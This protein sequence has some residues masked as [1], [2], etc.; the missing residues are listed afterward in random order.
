MNMEVIRLKIKPISSFKT[1]WASDTLMGAVYWSFLRREGSSALK[2]LLASFMDRQPPFLLSSGFPGDLFPRPFL[3]PRPVAKSRPTLQDIQE[4]KKFKKIAWI[5]LSSFNAV[6]N[7]EALQFEEN[8]QPFIKELVIHNQ[9][10]RVTCTTAGE[11]TMYASEET[12]LNERYYSY[13]SVYAYV[14]P[15]WKQT[16]VDL[17][18]DVGKNGLGGRSSTGKGAFTLE[19][20]DTFSGFASIENPNACITLGHMV[21]H[22]SDPVKGFYKITIK[23]GRLGEERAKLNN[24]FKKPLIMFVPGASFYHAGNKQFLGRMVSN[25]SKAAPDA[26]QCGMVPIVPARIPDLGDYA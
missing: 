8:E 24:P 1:N 11:G 16:L 19:G 7:G 25:V 14:L 10:D 13:L 18:E 23:R 6:R 26:V 21:P 4:A 15:E 12:F 3:P 5:S 9:I 2:D 17:I 22:A 20:Y